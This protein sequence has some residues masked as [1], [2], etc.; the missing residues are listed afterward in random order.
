[1]VTKES[2]LRM[3]RNTQI[4][5]GGTDCASSMVVVFVHFDLQKCSAFELIVQTST[6]CSQFCSCMLLL[7]AQHFS[8]D[9]LLLTRACIQI[10]ILVCP[11]LHS[12]R[13][14]CSFLSPVEMVITIRGRRNDKR[15]VHIRLFR[16][17]LCTSIWSRMCD[18]G[19]TQHLI[20]SK[21]NSRSDLGSL[22]DQ[23]KHSKDQQIREYLL[24]TDLSQRSSSALLKSDG[25]EVSSILQFPPHYFLFT[26]I[27]TPALWLICIKLGL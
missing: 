6:R 23:H 2:P 20:L 18:G 13:V 10:P 17:N 3:V 4:M 7:H 27:K 8:D 15:K 9:G 21:S 26:T 14:I 25:F 19:S 12:P 1:M 22:S 16:P 5:G 24:M 11:Y